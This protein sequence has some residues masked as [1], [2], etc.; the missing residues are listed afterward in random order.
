MV[1]DASYAFSIEHS[2]RLVP[3]RQAP[4][5]LGRRRAGVLLVRAGVPYW[6][7]RGAANDR[8]RALGP[9][10][11]GR[12]RPP[13]RHQHRRRAALDRP[14][15]SIPA[16]GTGE[17]RA[18]PLPGP[19]SP[20][21]PKSMREFKEGVLPPLLV[22]GAA[23]GADR[24]G[25]GHG[26]GHRAGRRPAW[27]CCAWPAPAPAHG[28]LFGGA[29]S[30]SALLF[31]VQALP[32]APPDGVPEPQGRPVPHRLSGLARADRPRLGRRDRLRAGR[33]AREAVPADGAPTSSSPSSPRSGA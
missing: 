24:Q 15:A 3:L 2:R 22:I 5:A 11:A 20:P 21:R 6:R 9:P 28:G 4:G 26:D 23:G 12:P 29:P 13:R 25:A 14:R 1:Y 32:A 33:R 30:P 18:R 16:V 19:R 8:R 10:A 7:W 17:T 31:A 27:S